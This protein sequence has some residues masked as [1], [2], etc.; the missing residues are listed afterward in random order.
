MKKTC[1]TTGVQR[2]SKQLCIKQQTRHS[3]GR[4]A[5]VLF[6]AA[7]C[8][9]PS[10]VIAAPSSTGKFQEYR[11]TS[12]ADWLANQPRYGYTIQFLAT[13]EPGV[14][15]QFI[16]R[17]RLEDIA[18]TITA[19]DDQTRQLVVVGSYPDRNNVLRAIKRLPPDLRRLKPSTR[20]F[21]SLRGATPRSAARKA[22]VAPVAPL[23]TV[24]SVQPS[25]PK[26]PSRTE[27]MAAPIPTQKI[28]ESPYGTDDNW[29]M[30][31]PPQNYTIQ[32]LAAA[33]STTFKKFIAD[34][35][36]EDVT[37]HTLRTD[38]DNKTW[39]VVITGSYP[40]SRDAL[41]EINQLAPGLQKLKPWVRSFNSLHKIMI[42]PANT[43]TVTEVVPAPEINNFSNANT[44]ITAGDST[45]LTT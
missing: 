10:T 39:Q 36:L 43:R 17:H 16:A 23:S 15:R 19:Y 24:T 42:Q 6:L 8:A 1:R 35:Q 26:P 3:S 9:Q 14:A 37:Y 29:V 40:D 38:Y 33:K 34:N 2:I 30:N 27:I 7:I 45:S 21:K 20:N 11:Y 41:K 5:V 22:T 28:G 31:Q 18:R 44:S 12:D 13:A 25:S 32:L 4:L